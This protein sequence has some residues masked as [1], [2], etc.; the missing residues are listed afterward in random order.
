MQVKGQI[1]AMRMRDGSYRT[2]SQLDRD[3][4]HYVLGKFITVLRSSMKVLCCGSHV[5]YLAR[6]GYS[7]TMSAFLQE[8]SS[9][10]PNTTMMVNQS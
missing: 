2:M 5:A 1:R 4:A 3:V 6:Q 8:C 9:L 7:H 10:P